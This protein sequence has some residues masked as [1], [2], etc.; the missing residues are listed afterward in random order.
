VKG[1]EAG[2]E[3]TPSF[4]EGVYSQLL[5]DLTH[6]SHETG[7]WVDVPNLEEFLTAG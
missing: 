2:K 1:I 7:T 4:K 5:M 3:M 6:Q